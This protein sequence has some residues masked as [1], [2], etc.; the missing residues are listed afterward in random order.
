MQCAAAHAPH[1]PTSATAQYVP[2]VSCRF[3]WLHHRWLACSRG[4][5]VGSTLRCASPLDVHA[6]LQRHLRVEQGYQQPMYSHAQLAE[7]AQ[8]QLQLLVPTAH[9]YIAAEEREVRQ[10]RPL[11][12]L[13]C[14][15]FVNTDS[16]CVPVAQQ[17]QK[18]QM[19]LCLSGFS[20]LL[21][22]ACVTVQR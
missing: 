14:L 3:G 11:A 5:A 7:F 18:H 2:V 12:V 17:S 22:M 21:A 4:P 13:S 20:P 10:S 6:C 16:G 15:Q 19:L 8:H 9:R 1:A